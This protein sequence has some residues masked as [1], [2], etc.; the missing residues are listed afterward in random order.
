MLRY[1]QRLQYQLPLLTLLFPVL[2]VSGVSTL[3]VV[4]GGT[5]YGDGSNL[6]G[7]TGVGAGVGVQ[8]EGSSVGTAGTLNFGTQ[9]DATTVNAGVTTITLSDTTV[10]AG[11]Y[12]AADIT[13]D[14]QGRIT[15]A[16]SGVATAN[17]NAD[18]L[19]VSGVS[20][21]GVTSTTNLTAEQLYVSGVSTFTGAI[22]ANGDLDV[23]GHTE[24]DNLN[25]SG[26]STFTGTR[27]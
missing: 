22:D 24:L 2:Q 17:I 8:K 13:V 9:F 1:R 21:L 15:A 5:Y 14:A 11:S 27:L 23:D 4:T 6:T 7:L 20:T 16:S 26:V 3:G 18:T 19:V 12:T 25:V 10:S